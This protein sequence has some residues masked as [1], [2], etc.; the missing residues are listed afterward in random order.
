MQSLFR[1]H[2][3]LRL[4]SVKSASHA[5]LGSLEVL[6]PDCFFDADSIRFRR[7]TRT[8]A[9]ADSRPKS[10]YNATQRELLHC[11]LNIIDT[12]TNS[13]PFSDCTT[14]T[15]HTST[16]SSNANVNKPC[17][18]LPC[19]FMGYVDVNNIRSAKKISNDAPETFSVLWMGAFEF[20]GDCFRT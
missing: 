18:W 4:P 9:T 16:N 14:S 2:R 13:V 10:I 15:R 12:G 17:S 20:W 8:A 19:V 11:Y 1:W 7:R 3:H 6:R 5:Y